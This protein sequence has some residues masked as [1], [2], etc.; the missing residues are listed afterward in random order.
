MQDPA[1]VEQVTK[2]MMTGIWARLLRR[3]QRQ[4][5]IVAVKKTDQKQ[6]TGEDRKDEPRPLRAKASNST[7]NTLMFKHG[8]RRGTLVPVGEKD[9]KIQDRDHNT[10]RYTGT[11]KTGFPQAIEPV[12]PYS[13]FG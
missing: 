6:G 12:H 13:G 11:F 7:K 5:R 9:I 4:P 8:R 10:S 2:S 3:W 1:F